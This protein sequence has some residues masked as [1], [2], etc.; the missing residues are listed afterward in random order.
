MIRLKPLKIFA[1]VAAVAGGA[2]AAGAQP[3]PVLYLSSVE[4]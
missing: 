2:S 3:N 4:P 1:A